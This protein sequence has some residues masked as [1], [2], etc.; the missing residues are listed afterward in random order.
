MG[1]NVRKYSKE[2]ILE[3]ARKY[4]NQRD[5]KINEVS[6][7]RCAQG[8]SKPNKSSEDK[9]FWELCISHMEYIFRPNGY[10]TYERCKKI[11]KKFK[12]IKEFSRDP[13]YYYVYKTIRKNGW[14]DLIKHLER[15]Y[16]VKGYWT[17]ERCKEEALK[18][19][20]R[21]E[22]S[23]RTAY[24]KIKR[25]GWNEL[26]SHMK[27]RMT[28][29]QRVIYSYEFPQNNYVYVGLTC[30]IER[31]HNAHM[32]KETRYG[33]VVSSVYELMTKTGEIPTFKILSKKPIK[34]ENAPRSEE[35][36][37]KKYKDNGWNILNKTKAGS[38]GSMYKWT[39]DKLKTICD[40]CNKVSELKKKIPSWG[41]YSLKENDWYDELTSHMEQDVRK[42]WTDK[43]VLEI[44]YRYDTISLL[45]KDYNGVAKYIRKRPTLRKELDVYWSRRKEEI[46]MS[47]QPTKEECIE[48]ALKYHL[49]TKFRDNDRRIFEFAKSNG[50]IDE[51]CSHMTLSYWTYERCKEGALR[52]TNKRDLSK[53]LKGCYVVIC[54]NKWYELISHMPVRK[55]RNDGKYMGKYTV[56]K[57]F[58]LSKL[59][60]NVSDFQKKYS[61]A[62]KSAIKLGIIKEL[63]FC[64]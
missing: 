49:R 54:Q 7:Y 27:R 34:E 29:K 15:S 37:L 63:N 44:A 42:E 24:G 28:L 46:E 17:Y 16:N 57:L 64:S 9:K 31:R 22:F 62:H 53:N 36:Y 50:W 13:E 45:Q 38:L 19:K 18:Y 56:E 43:E 40:S 47:K 39:K 8:Y 51:I 3:S 11:S 2:E 5:W 52:Y 6:I 58:E 30:Q 59:C 4:R 33:K 21:G 60:K 12:T 61:G 20:T 48:T 1:T 55:L 25:N 41:F 10:W 23:N 14:T 32:G 35:Y 26:L